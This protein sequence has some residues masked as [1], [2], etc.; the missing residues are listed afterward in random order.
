MVAYS[1]TDLF[2]KSPALRSFVLS[3]TNLHDLAYMKPVTLP[4]GEKKGHPRGPIILHTGTL[5]I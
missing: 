4:G 2:L 3:N 5:E 1:T